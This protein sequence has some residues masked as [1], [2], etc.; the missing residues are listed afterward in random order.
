MLCHATK[1]AIIGFSISQLCA[2]RKQTEFHSKGIQMNAQKHSTNQEQQ[3]LNRPQEPNAPFSYKEEE[4]FYENATAAVQLA[5]TLTLPPSGVPC[6]AVVLIAG[7][8]RNDRDMTGMGH[9]YFLV[10]ADHLTRQGIAVL[11]FDKR[12]VGKSSGSYENATSQDFASD[13]QAG[14]EY[15]KTRK[16]I[17]P[18]KIGLM[19]LSEGGLI[20]SMV[21]AELKDIAFILLMAPAILTKID[22]LVEMAGR[23]LRADGASEEFIAGDREV[24]SAIMS[25]VKQESVHVAHKKA[26]EIIATYLAELPEAQKSEADKLPF[27][28]TAAKADMLIST[29]NSCWYRF[30]L[31]YDPAIAFRRI[32]IPVLAITGDKDW[33]VSP[34]KL[35]PLLSQWLQ[36]ANN[37]DV[38]L[39]KLPNLNHV[40]QTC[41]TGA[42][43]EYG[44]I[45]ETMSPLAL[46]IIAEWICARTL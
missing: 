8:G 14:V 7:Y 37:K 46:K 29:F 18:D 16:E 28:F 2:Y 32:K 33:I 12:G 27:A 13:V 43:M 42:I 20:A 21:A 10:L 44:L 25:L 3:Q 36:Q 6:P 5:G 38:T 4:V 45:E 35:F 23:Q 39:L 9:K 24:R 19:G 26:K 31:A 30:F 41:Q 1:L 40:F 11:R 34:D 15:L 22:D 17:N